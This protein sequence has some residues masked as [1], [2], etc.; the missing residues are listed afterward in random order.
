[1]KIG[2][3]VIYRQEIYY[4]V[5]HALIEKMDDSENIDFVEALAVNKVETASTQ[6]MSR[7]IWLLKDDV[8]TMPSGIHFEQSD[9]YMGV[10]SGDKQP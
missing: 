6:R 4:V 7:A 9:W 5:A 1:M 2:D 8:L 3:M 10:E